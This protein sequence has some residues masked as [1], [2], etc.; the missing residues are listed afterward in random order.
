VRALRREQEKLGGRLRA[1]RVE[2]G[3]TIERA[4]E[5][6]GLHDGYLGRLERGQSNVTLAVLVALA[7]AYSVTVD[8]I[9]RDRPPMAPNPRVLSKKRGR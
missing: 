1:L 6:S 2:R 3:L 8:D 4:A 5:R 7:K 9:F